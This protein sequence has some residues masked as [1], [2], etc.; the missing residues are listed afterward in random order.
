MKSKSKQLKIISKKYLNA[1]DFYYSNDHSA[2]FVAKK[3]QLSKNTL[4]RMVRLGNFEELPDG[5][6]A[7]KDQDYYM[8]KNIMH[9]YKTT[10]KSANELC[11][12]FNVG[13]SSFAKNLKYF[14]L[15]YKGRSNLI[16]FKRDIFSKIDS[17]DKAYWLGFILADGCIYKN[18]LRLKLGKV[19]YVHLQKYCDFLGL[20]HNHIVKDAHTIKVIVCDKKMIIDLNKLNIFSK[21]SCKEIPPIIDPIFHRDLLRGFF[22]GDGCIKT[23]LASISLVGSKDM[24]DFCNKVFHEELGIPLGKVY[25]DKKVYRLAWYSLFNKQSILSWLYDGS[26]TYLDRKFS[27]AKK[28]GRL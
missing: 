18:E 22:D 1:L 28:I 14:N 26:H 11:L 24:M 13:K 10:N 17:S 4:L 6:I 23:N 9:I 7:E 15:S 16:E 5:N 3:F 20:S 27:L 21:K 12:E 19:D 2:T 8:W 25:S